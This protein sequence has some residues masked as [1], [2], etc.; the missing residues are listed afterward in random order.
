MLIT[1]LIAVSAAS[2]VVPRLPGAWRA[3]SYLLSGA[4]TMQPLPPDPA[5]LAE[6]RIP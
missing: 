4:P 6:R 1:I 2:L 5:P 3:L